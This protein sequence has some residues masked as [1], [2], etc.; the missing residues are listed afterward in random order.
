[1]MLNS[2]VAHMKLKHAMANDTL[3][4][5][6]DLDYPSLEVVERPI[7]YALVT[8]FS[9]TAALSLTGNITVIL[10]LS[11]GHRY[12]TPSLN[13]FIQNFPSLIQAH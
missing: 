6:L 9:L 2:L 5:D 10:V 3:P 13:C 11:L 7:Q 8:I 12:S 1:M 4:D